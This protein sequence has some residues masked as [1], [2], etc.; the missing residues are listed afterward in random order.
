[1]YQFPKPEY[2]SADRRDSLVLILPISLLWK[3]QIN[4][5]QKLLLGLV[6]SLTI[7]VII[8]AIVR[9]TVVLDQSK[10]LDLTWL[11]TWAVIEQTVGELTYVFWKI[12]Q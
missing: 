10:Q 6:L 2:V 7:F 1:M 4:V 11:Y 5:R 9:V 8:T 12:S 3:V